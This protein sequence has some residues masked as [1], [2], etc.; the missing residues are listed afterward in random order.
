[1]IDEETLDITCFPAVRALI[2][3]PDGADHLL[4]LCLRY[5]ECPTEEV[6]V[7]Y[8]E[9]GCDD[10]RCAPNRILE[11]YEFDVLVDPELPAVPPAQ[12]QPPT[13]AW[14]ASKMSCALRL[15][16]T[17]LASRRPLGEQ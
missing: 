15:H 1:M 12:P 8:D 2:E 3:Q 10:T 13:L 17:K 5:R 4:L 11:S 7:L 6:P 14:Q 9:C 16:T